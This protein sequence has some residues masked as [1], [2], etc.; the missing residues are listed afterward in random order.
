MCSEFFSDPGSI[1]EATD[2]P[3]N[4]SSSLKLPSPPI[5]AAISATAENDGEDLQPENGT[6]GVSVGGVPT[7]TQPE[8][9][10]IEL[11]DLVSSNKVKDTEKTR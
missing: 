1:S 6:T 4:V 10:K 2:I 5:H 8:V 11:Q 3:D 9:G 7:N